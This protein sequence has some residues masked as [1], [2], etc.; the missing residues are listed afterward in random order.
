MPNQPED[1]G[2]QE[3]E[4]ILLEKEAL[5]HKPKKRPTAQ[6]VKERLSAKFE[7]VKKTVDI[8]SDL[9]HFRLS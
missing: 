9:M 6:D 1:S 8:S 4:R 7:V 5:K 2:E 3:Q